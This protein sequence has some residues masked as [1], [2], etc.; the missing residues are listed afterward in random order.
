MIFFKSGDAH[1]GHT[2]LSGEET[3]ALIRSSLATPQME[4][5]GC[6]FDGNCPH[7]FIVFGA[8]VSPFI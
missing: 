4:E 7:V 1:N 3:L 2:E 6:C 5:D 8:S